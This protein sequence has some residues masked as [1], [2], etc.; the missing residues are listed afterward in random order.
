MT[1]KSVA[2]DYLG[3]GY[4]LCGKYADGESV[5][6]QIFDLSKVPEHALRQLSNREAQY[7]SVSGDSV[8]EYQSQLAVKAGISG[9]Y[10]LFSASVESSFS[11]TDLSI[12]ESSYVSVN[13]CMRYETWKLQVT[14]KEYMHSNVEEDFNTKDGKWLIEQYGAGVVMGMD[15]GG[16]WSDNLSVSKLYTESKTDVTVSMEAA[17]G[18]FISGKGSVEVSNVA[19]SKK[20]IASR[21]VMVVGGNPAFAPGQLEDWQKSV[22][23]N[24]AFMNFTKDGVAMIWDL[25]PEHSDKLKKGFEEYLKE[26]Q[27]NLNKKRLVE[28]MYVEGHK[29][30]DDE[31][32]VAD[33]GV[34]LYKPVISGDYKFLGVSGNSNKV[35]VLRA[36]SDS[37]G[38]LREPDSWQRV[39]FNIGLHNNRFYSCWLPR[40][41]P[42]FVALG[43]YCRFNIDNYDPPNREEV[44][45]MVVVHKSLAEECDFADADIWNSAGHYIR[46]GGSA[47]VLRDITLGRLPSEALWPV[48][49][50]DREAGDLPRAY[51]LKDEYMVSQ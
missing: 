17:Y 13:L 31:G 51:K 20:S 3:S 28:A 1:E 5:K 21:R 43:V 25:F 50:T 14:S 37:Y 10:G 4:D 42:G 9:S 29:Y 7:F 15:I 34:S 11:S 16:R 35:L 30:A 8:E 6:K 2:R 32:Y 23:E 45:G 41:A 47:R 12:S 49:T 36:I 33:R 19:K 24:P 38:A 39:W 46:G 40:A 27:L 44:N 26:K 22:E 18:S 48:R